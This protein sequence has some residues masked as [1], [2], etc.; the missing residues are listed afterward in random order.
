MPTS[1][2]LGRVSVQPAFHDLILALTGPIGAVVVVD[3]EVTAG[4]MC[5]DYGELYWFAAPRACVVDKKW[6]KTWLVLFA[7]SE[8]RIL[9]GVQPRW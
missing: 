6:S 1:V 4:R 7:P 5:L 8:V 2:L 9:K 3:C